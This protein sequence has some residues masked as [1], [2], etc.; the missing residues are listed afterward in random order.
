MD[1][2]EKNIVELLVENSRES[3]TT[4][5][6]VYNTW[7]WQ[8]T[9]LP[10]NLSSNYHNAIVDWAYPNFGPKL[11]AQIKINGVQPK[12]SPKQILTKIPTLKPKKK[13][14]DESPDFYFRNSLERFGSLH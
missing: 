8:M 11:K 12:P 3:S 4:P 10:L 9:N 6:P 1:E 5:H 7:T 13:N 14:R 2:E